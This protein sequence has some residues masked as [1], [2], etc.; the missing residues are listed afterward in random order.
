MS[1]AEI[2]S[3]IKSKTVIGL[4]IALA[5]DV[6]DLIEKAEGT[7]LIPHEYA[8]LIRSVGLALALLGRWTAKLPLGLSFKW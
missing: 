1:E 5:P 4:I 3:P 8:P 6:V 7:G 2:K